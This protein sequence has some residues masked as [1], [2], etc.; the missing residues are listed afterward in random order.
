MEG[1]DESERKQPLVPCS[2]KEKKGKQTFKVPIRIGDRATSDV[3]VRLRTDEGRDNWFYCHSQILI[4]KS[5][6]FADRLSEDWPTCQILDSR[7]CVE[8]YC[9]EVEFNF[10]VSALRLFYVTEP[11]TWHGV[12]NTLGILQVADHLGC[13]QMARD[14]IDYLE[15][16]PWEEAEEEEI[17]RT[18]PHLGSQYEQILARLQPVDPTAVLGIFISA[19]RFATSSPP[20]SM[21]ELKSS[22]QDQLEYMLTEDDDVPILAFDNEIMKFEV[23][24]CVRD[25][26]NRFNHLIESFLSTSLDMNRI[27]DLQSLLSD[28]SWICQILSKMEMMKELIHYWVD[29]SVNIVKSVEQ[30][31]ANDDMLDARLKVVEVASKVLE[32][33]GFGNVILPPAKRLHVVKVWLPF[34]QRTRPLV[35]QVHPDDEEVSSVRIDSEIWQNLESAF[36]SIVLTLP[37]Q[38]QAEILAEWLR[39]EHVRYPDLTEA[40]EVWCYRSK[41]AKRRLASLGGLGTMT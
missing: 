11:H 16:V 12:R 22:A 6:Y 27:Q 4:E 15:A 26:L 3:I 7:N 31:N 13:H 2:S 35:G 10:H 5:K 19:I 23:K 34:V 21:R 30:A 28:I 40:F 17:L 18:I 33:A 37:S 41:I 25:L 9:R 8:V 20:P 29:A 14:C 39:S 1:V 38:D 24:T 32:A 36:V